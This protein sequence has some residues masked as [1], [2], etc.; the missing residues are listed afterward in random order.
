MLW[1]GPRKNKMLHLIHAPVLGR[2]MERETDED[3]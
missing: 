1:K 3:H 2:I